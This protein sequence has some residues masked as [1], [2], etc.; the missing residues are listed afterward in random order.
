M[1]E[2]KT[3]PSSASTFFGDLSEDTRSIWI[4]EKALADMLSLRKI[5]FFKDSGE[6]TCQSPYLALTL[7]IIQ[8]KN[9]NLFRHLKKLSGGGISR[10]EGF[11]GTLSEDASFDDLLNEC[12]MRGLSGMLPLETLLFVWDQCFIG[13]FSH[14]LPLILSSLLLADA[15]NIEKL[16]RFGSIADTWLSNCAVIEVSQ[17]QRYIFRHV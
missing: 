15:E 6:I 17:L 16:S 8:K 1:L 3:Q 11:F 7:N 9:E 14:M 2:L 12:L 5:G 13:G 10:V 4:I